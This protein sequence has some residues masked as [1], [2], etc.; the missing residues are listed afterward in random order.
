MTVWDDVERGLSRDPATELNTAQEACGR[1]SDAPDRLALVVRHS[2][3]SRERWTHAELY[4]AAAR[5]A[6][7]FARAG[8]RR[9]DRVA[10]L[11]G[12]Q[13]ESWIV[14]LAAWR[15]GLVYVPLFGGLGTDALA[16][17]LRTSGTRLLVVDHTRRRA[18]AAALAVADHDPVVLA[19]AARDGSGIAQGD[20]DF[21]AACDG[22]DDGPDRRTSAADLATLLFTSGTTGEPKACTMPHSALLSVLRFARHSLGAGP[23]STVFTAADPGWAY[24][25]YSTG[26]APMALGSPRVLYSGDFD[27]QAWWRIVREESVSCLA[28]APSA[29]RRLL[30]PLREHG[31]PPALEIAAAAG[32]PLDA[33]TAIGWRDAGGP[34]VRD[35]YGLTEVGMVLADLAGGTP[36]EPGTL[37]G[38]VPGF[39]VLLVDPAGEPVEPG[40]DGLIAVRRPRHQLSDGYENKADAWSANWHGDLFITGDRAAPAAGGRWRFLGRGDD[41]IVASGY[42]IGPVE[43]ERV[44]ADHPAVRE[45]AAV[46]G[47]GPGGSTVVRAVL[48]PESGRPTGEVLERELADA[49]RR[50]IGAHARPRLFTYVD[51]LPRNEVGKLQ[52]ARLRAEGDPDV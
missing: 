21:R 31:A 41:M 15:S 1:W 6:G 48:V 13:V 34:A 26:A 38:P 27:P 22:A 51:A 25:L 42:N 8:L 35:G 24:G 4:R 49:V 11:L 9:G 16:Y 46:A 29:Y 19:V 43:V 10:G 37:G 28:A 45:A 30:E 3:G 50:R 18:A 33:G 23:R 2:D 52:R 39:D 47:T 17:R 36:P 12:R 7:V 5:A 14:A 44:L 20:T 32:E 40:A